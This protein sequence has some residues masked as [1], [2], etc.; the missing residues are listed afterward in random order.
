MSLYISATQWLRHGTLGQ[1]SRGDRYHGD[2]GRAESADAIIGE[3]FVWC[4]FGC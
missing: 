2:G 3:D 4:P 1:S